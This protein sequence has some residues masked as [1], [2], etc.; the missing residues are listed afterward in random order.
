MLATIT[1]TL[2]GYADRREIRRNLNEVS[3]FIESSLSGKKHDCRKGLLKLDTKDM[4]LI[5]R[6][7][8]VVIS[9]SVLLKVVE[10]IEVQHLK[11]LM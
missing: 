8:G 10:K 6:L 3:I 4:F 1:H 2:L 9:F 11:G 5:L 7:E